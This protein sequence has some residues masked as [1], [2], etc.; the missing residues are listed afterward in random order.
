M[1]V[2]LQ[3]KSLPRLKKNSIFLRVNF[4][5]V[6]LNQATKSYFKER[7]MIRPRQR[8]NFTFSSYL[9]FLAWLTCCLFSVKVLWMLFILNWRCNHRNST[10]PKHETVLEKS[11]NMMSRKDCQKKK[12]GNLVQ[13]YFTP[14]IFSL[15]WSELGFHLDASEDFFSPVFEQV[16]SRSWW[17]WIRPDTPLSLHG[18][19]RSD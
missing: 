1:P 18:F 3:A 13:A 10:S 17:T 8:N 7:K 11:W 15:R 14:S 2:V 16:N 9:A 12:S 4:L 5:F 19:L 6:V